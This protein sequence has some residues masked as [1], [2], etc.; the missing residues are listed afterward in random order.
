MQ[1][2]FDPGLY[3]A[4]LRSRW[5]LPAAALALAVCASLAFTSLQPRRYT[6]RVSLLIEP[7]ASSEPRA[8]L[9]VSPIYLE[10]LRT[11]EHFASSDALFAQAA[12]KF[13]LQGNLPDRPPLETLKRRVLRV[14][15]PRNTKILEI[16]VTLPDA[17]RAHALASYLA[18]HTVELNR[19]TSRSADEEFVSAAALEQ[20]HA[21]ERFRSAEAQLQSARRRAPTPQA[22]DADL[23]HLRE[24]RAQIQ[25]LALMNDL[26]AADAERYGKVS[27]AGALRERERSIDAEI[28]AKQQLLADRSAEIDRL[29]AEYAAAREALLQAEKRRRDTQGMAGHRSERIALLDPG[30]VPERPSA[31]SLPL[32]LLLAVAFASMA[33]L[34]WLTASFALRAPGAKPALRLPRVVGKL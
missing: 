19:S 33:S 6:A 17:R 23:A 10:S 8:A 32:N 21:A 1:D 2:P 5:R 14:T 18:E 7:P 13:D 28:A 26:S 9:A 11:Y 24:T 22:L 29:G 25:R 4:Y 15:I 27:G 3:F 20:E 12:A 34:V 31:P 30:F 16:S